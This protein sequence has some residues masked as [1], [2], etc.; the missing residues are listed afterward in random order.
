MFW[1]AVIVSVMLGASA[2]WAIRELAK[3]RGLVFRPVSVRHVHSSPIP[4]VGGVA[5]FSTFVIVYGLYCL[6]GYVGFI[7]RPPTFDGLKIFASAILLFAAGLIDDLR[8]LTA[9]TKLFVQTVGGICLYLSGFHFFCFQWPALGPVL[10]SAVCLIATVFWVVLVCN[11]INLI[12]G[13]DGLA[14]GAAMFSMVTIVT[15]ALLQGRTS[16][17]MG[18]AVL[19]GALFG[20]LIFNFN[21]ASIFLGDGGSLFVGFML[22]GFVLAETPKERPFAAIAIPALALALPLLDTTLSVVRRLLS[23][24]ALF[25]ADRDHIHHKLLEIGLSHRQVVWILYGFC[26]ISVVL[27]LTIVRPSRFVAIPAVTI[28]LLLVFFGLRKLDYRELSEVKRLWRRTLQQRRA[29]AINIAIRKACAELRK[30][31]QLSKILGLLEGCLK[32]EFEGFE[33]VLDEPFARSDAGDRLWHANLE[34]FWGFS[35]EET[36]VFTIELA[37]AKYGRIARL[38]LYRSQESEWLPDIDLLTGEFRL[39]LSMAL[40]NCLSYEPAT[41]KLPGEMAAL[42]SQSRMEVLEDA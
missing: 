35:L 31:N 4:R 2:T 27:S 20:F 33:I 7:Q 14:A 28:L 41:L 40:E 34:R 24:H 11:A 6:A 25:G 13:L 17:A 3:G 15:V 39:G 8:G 36:T 22:S 29:F 5:V 9:R 16:I 1:V 42:A 18:T 21:P 37:T 19:A 30:S 26:A 32:P 38:S 12:D 10:S 23:G